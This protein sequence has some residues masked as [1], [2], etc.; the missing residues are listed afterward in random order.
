[1]RP[2]KENDMETEKN[3]DVAPAIPAAENPPL[4]FCIEG[5][6]LIGGQYD[7]MGTPHQYMYATGMN[8]VG[9]SMLRCDDCEAVVVNVFGLKLANGLKP[10][11]AYWEPGST[12]SSELLVPTRR[13]ST[14]LYC[15]RC[16]ARQ[17]MNCTSTQPSPPYDYMDP[18]PLNWRCAGHPVLPRYLDGKDQLAVADELLGSPATQGEKYLAADD[19]RLMLRAADAELHEVLL[20][21][22][23]ETIA[24]GEGLRLSR[25]LATVDAEPRAFIAQLGAVDPDHVR[26]RAEDEARGG[27]TLRERLSHAVG[28]C[29]LDAR[30]MVYDWTRLY[31]L[32]ERLFPNTRSLRLIQAM[33]AY[34]SNRVACALLEAHEALSGKTID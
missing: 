31:R 8:V 5:G 6:Y 23:S 4:H 19:L 11:E 14:R 18:T 34:D 9:C 26:F 2:A 16:T 7:R 28:T 24:K 1:M 27:W 32:F 15:C 10:H 25:A 17:E 33:N 22:L 20:A 29:V 13:E 30:K 12:P 3:E 21:L